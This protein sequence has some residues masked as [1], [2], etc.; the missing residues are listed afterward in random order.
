MRILNLVEIPEKKVGAG[1]GW[2]RTDWSYAIFG[3]TFSDSREFLMQ[4][5]QFRCE[6]PM[7]RSTIAEVGHE[8]ML[9]IATILTK[10]LNALSDAVDNYG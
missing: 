7:M 5:G 9:N 6:Q 10:N 2:Q 3:I 4:R 8:E 1:V